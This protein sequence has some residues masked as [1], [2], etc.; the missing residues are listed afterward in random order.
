VV[1]QPGNGGLPAAGIWKQM[2]ISFYA[3]HTLL[4]VQLVGINPTTSGITSS[5]Y[6]DDI[7]VYA[8]AQNLTTKKTITNPSFASG[9]T[10]WPIEV[11]ADGTGPGTWSALSSWSG[12]TAVLRSV[13]LGGQKGKASQLYSASTS[14]TLGSI[15]VYSSATSM[16]NTQKIYLYIY[17]YDSSYTKIVE[18]GNAILQSG[19]WTPGTW[20]QLQFEYIPS[21]TKNAVQFVGINPSGK[22]TG[23]LYFDEVELMQ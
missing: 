9:T 23:T 20:R 15:W 11:Y 19:K 3:Q 5:L 8:G 12:H 21:S 14:K 1:I 22:P 7:W 6:L 18:S 16:S 2:Q 13:Q 4:G 10:G 17:S